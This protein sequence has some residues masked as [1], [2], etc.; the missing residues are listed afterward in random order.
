M[1]FFKKDPS[2]LRRLRWHT[3][4][5]VY[6]EQ[7]FKKLETLVSVEACQVKIWFKQISLEVT[8]SHILNSVYIK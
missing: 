6:F 1:R 7:T 4:I 2:V 8:I 5:N 3:S